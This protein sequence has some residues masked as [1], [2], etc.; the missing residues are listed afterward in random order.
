MD[1]VICKALMIESHDLL[2][3][4]L[5]VTI[6]L[7]LTLFIKAEVL[8][9]LTQVRVGVVTVVTLVRGISERY[10]GTG[11]RFMIQFD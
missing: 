1:L 4:I 5:S 3:F 7:F 6:K 11:S 10:R 2:G 9:C 8:D